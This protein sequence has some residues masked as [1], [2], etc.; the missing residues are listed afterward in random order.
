M[1]DVKLPCLLIITVAVVRMGFVNNWRLVTEDMPN[2][3]GMYIDFLS[4]G[5]LMLTFVR[6]FAC[7]LHWGDSWVVVLTNWG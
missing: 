1:H 4:G 5:D 7:V 2:F 3:C 6:C